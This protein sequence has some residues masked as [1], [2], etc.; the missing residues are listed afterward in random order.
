MGSTLATNSKIM[1]FGGHNVA[2][3]VIAGY[4]NQTRMHPKALLLNDV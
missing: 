3:F 2:P 4:L 1:A